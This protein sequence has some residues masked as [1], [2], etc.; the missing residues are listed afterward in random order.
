MKATIID[1]IKE[2]FKKKENKEA[3]GKAPEGVC[4]NCWGSQEWDGHF[5]E[6]MRAKNISPMDDTYNSFIKEIV[7]KHIN[8]IIIDENT[9]TCATC[10]IKYD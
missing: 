2:Y 9:Y 1:N 7:T 10:Q 6:L 8:G 5:Y 4:P 3:T